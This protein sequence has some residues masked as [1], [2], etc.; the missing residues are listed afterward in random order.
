MTETPS[1]GPSLIRTWTPILVG[2][3]VAWLISLG[4]DVSDEVQAGLVVLLTAVL[5][6]V[7]Y[8]AARLL[9]RRWPRLTVLLGSTQQPDSY[10]PTGTVPTGTVTPADPGQPAAGVPPAVTEGPDTPPVRED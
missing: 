1:I 8:L 4:I 7:Y 5:Q 2:A 6:G 3:L 10:S 9:E